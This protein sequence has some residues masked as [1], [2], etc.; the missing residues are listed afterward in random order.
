MQRSRTEPGC[1]SHD[2]HT[3]PEQPLRVFFFERWDSLDALQAHFVV[4][5][6]REFGRRLGKLAAE[7]PS[8]TV[9][10]AEVVKP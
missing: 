3:G 10:A 5:A 8:M 7:P 6:S 1:V 2:M 9:Y 4:P